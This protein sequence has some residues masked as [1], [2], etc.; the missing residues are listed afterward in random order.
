MDIEVGNQENPG[1]TRRSAPRSGGPALRQHSTW[2]RRS[3]AALLASGVAMGAASV[4][5]MNPAHAD[6]L[7]TPALAPVAQAGSDTVKADS[8][9]TLGAKDV[10]LLN[11][12]EAKGETKVTVIIATD[13]GDAA[14]VAASVHKLGGTVSRRYDKVGYVLAE[15]PTAKVRKAAKLPGVAAIDLDDVVKLPDPKADLAATSAR[16]QSLALATGPGPT[17]PAVNPYLPTNEIGAVDFKKAHPT[18][19]GRGIT[20]GIM[21]SGVDLDHPAL[22]KTTT[23]A[24]KIT[25]WVTATDPTIDSDGTWRPMVTSV[26]GPTFTYKSAT[27]TAPAGTWQI[28]TFAEAVTAGSEEVAGDVNRDGDTTDVWG[29]LYN[30]ATHDIRV[31]TNQ[32]HDFTD[33]AVM[34]PYKEKFDIGHFGTDNPATEVHESMPF[35]VE[36]RKF[37][38]SPG[39]QTDFV[40]IGIAEEA[41]ATHV[42]GITAG[43]DMFG[44]ADFDGVAP[45]AT[46][47]SERACNWSGGCTNAALTTGMVDLVE[48]RHANVVNLSIGG[49]SALNDGSDAQS[50]LY[51][52]L[53]T[54][55]GVQLFISAG[56]AGPGLNTVGSP[57]TSTAAVSVAA[58]VSADTYLADYGA[59]TQKPL[60]IFNFSSRGPREDGGFKPGISAPGAAI[61]SVPMWQPGQPVP[62]AGYALP[63]GYAMYNGTS[64]AAPQATGGAALLLSAAKAQDQ[65]VTPAALRQ[66]IYS[67]AKPIPG[68]STTAQGNGQ[69]NV[70]G[71]WSLL[72]NKISTRSFTSTAPVCTP[73]SA[74]LTTPGRGEGIYNRCGQ[75]AGSLKNYTI[76]LTRTSGPDKTITHN[77]S[78]A[79]ST[80]FSSAKTVKLPLN[81]AV[82]VVVTVR[83]AAGL[84]SAILRVDDPATVG[85]DYETLNTVLA[86]AKPSKP[87]YGFATGDQ[88]VDR[89]SANSYFV[90]VPAGAA[91]LQVNFSG[92]ASGERIQF[93]AT[94]PYGMPVED[95]S[96][97]CVTNSADPAVCKAIER[98]YQNPMPGVWEIEVLGARTTPALSNP[99]SLTARVQGVT[100]SPSIVTLPSVVAGQASPVTWSVANDFG[101]VTVTGQGQPLGSA[102]ISRPTVGQDE[103]KA[104]PIEV[105][106]GVTSLHVAIKNPADQ[107]ADLDL[108]VYLNG[109]VVA[110]DADGDSDEKVTIANPA[111]GTYTAV[112]I[113]YSVPA[114]TTAFD[115]VDVYY[116]PGMGSVVASATPRSLASGAKSTITGAVQA[117]TVG[118]AAGRVLYG[119]MSVVTDQGAIVGHGAVAVNEVK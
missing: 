95:S 103:T 20:I 94:D 87:D 40:G 114:G 60:Q 10:S 78:W 117:G 71:A 7:P 65:A 6:P 30:P 58:S 77:L 28:N 18:W 36:Y 35:T 116:T 47:V 9:D 38:T 56:N 12:A 100:V 115:Y 24:R 61:S 85:F 50:M 55:Y 41:H 111:A 44:D 53:I 4:T 72:S 92:L 79:G 86:P 62:D 99:Y 15:I 73:L 82:S 96:L 90:T 64:M 23:G 83:A 70:P 31:D 25:D 97:N 46:I 113:G 54:D 75:T 57:S 5:G 110:S 104:I 45:G 29:V 11:A 52:R 3:F 88:A 19:D 17:T 59:V 89:N 66:S 93:L 32:N 105:P 67:S 63:A 107:S 49:L 37:E 48:V 16:K 1:Q 84:N 102:L 22:Q 39:V 34:R 98:D 27:W 51:N 76:K 81:K 8:A 21:D 112:I 14:S 68:Y 69:F 2:G 119:E 26:T 80:A 109:K 74:Y 33:D 108:E 43:N 91:A 13:K 106:A 101:P 42:A 118:P